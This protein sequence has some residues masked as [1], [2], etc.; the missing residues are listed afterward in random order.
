MVASRKD[1]AKYK[2][3]FRSFDKDGSGSISIDE[4]GALLRSVGHAPTP[5]E[6]MRIIREVDT[7]C[8]GQIEFEEFL[9]MIASK[10]KNCDDEIEA[11]FKLFDKDGD[12]FISE[13]ELRDVMVSVGENLTDAQIKGMMAVADIDGDNRV[14]FED[15]RGLM[16]GNSAKD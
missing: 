12:G 15:F 9:V 6:L 1:I 13:D 8:S 3:A 4:L 5:T 10:D 11:A 2:E 7:D 16:T 14:G